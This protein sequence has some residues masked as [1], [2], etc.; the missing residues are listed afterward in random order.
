MHQIRYQLHEI[1]NNLSGSLEEIVRETT[2]LKEEIKSLHDFLDTLEIPRQG[3]REYGWG[4]LL[5]GERLA[6]SRNQGARFQK[7]DETTSV[8]E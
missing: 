7:I 1:T 2:K 3:Q 6:L 4:E 5:L 8:N